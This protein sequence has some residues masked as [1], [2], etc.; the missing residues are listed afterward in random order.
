[1]LV[2]GLIIARRC[3]MAWPLHVMNFPENNASKYLYNSSA[4]EKAEMSINDL[5]KLLGVSKEE[6]EAMLQK[7]DTISLDLSEKAGRKAR[8]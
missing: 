7:E 4:L 1:V 5:A 3:G 2:F 8:F 6:A